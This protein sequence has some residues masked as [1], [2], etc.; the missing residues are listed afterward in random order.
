VGTY[1]N[2]GKGTWRGP[3]LWD[4][5]TG[6][7]KNFYPV[8]SHERLSF[9]LRGEFFNLFNHP[10][11]SDPNVNFSNAA[12]GSTRAT[13]GTATGNVATT[14]DSRIIQLALKMLF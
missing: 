5:D 8:P 6:L 11:W 13:L 9:Q 12:F 2:A 1:G 4:V 10:Q 14:A 7:I 3:T